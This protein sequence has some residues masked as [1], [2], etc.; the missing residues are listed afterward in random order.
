[1][2]VVATLLCDRKRNSWLKGLESVTRLQFQQPWQI[3]V[4]L[5]Q[6]GRWDSGV[7]EPIFDLLNSCTIPYDYDFWSWTSTWWTAPKYDQDQSRLTPIVNA[8]NMALAYARATGA[9]ALMF[10]DADVIVPPHALATLEA[11]GKSIVGGMVPGRGV[12]RAMRYI[13]GETNTWEGR[14]QICGHGTLGCCLIRREVFDYLSF[15]WGP[16]Y[17]N[18]TILSEDPAYCNDAKVLLGQNFWMHHDVQCEHWDDPDA[19]LT[20]DQ[21]AGF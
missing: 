15:R 20:D 7:Y 14:L 10:V 12:H 21:V 2:I 6:T 5:E 11:C 16:A 4:N 1:M 13:F 3:Y 19:P 9:S 8:R 17:P 18:G